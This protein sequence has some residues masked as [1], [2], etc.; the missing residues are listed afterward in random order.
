MPELFDRDEADFQEL[1][2][3]LKI[4]SIMTNFNKKIDDYIYKAQPFAQPVLMHIRNLVHKACP[5][6]EE[7]I[8][9]SFPHFDY[10]GE[11]LCSMASFKQHCAF[12]FWKG[13]IMKDP[14]GILAKPKTAMGHL[15]QIKSLKD[16]PSDKIMLKYIRQAMQLNDEKIKLPARN[17]LTSE[18]EIEVPDILLKALKENKEANVCWQSFSKSH[19]KEYAEWIREAKTIETKNK[20][21]AT[22]IEWLKEG[23][24]RNWKYKR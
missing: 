6:A 7:K 21:L 5:E 11:M 24:D 22:T 3:H 4:K 2:Y 9:W 18:S 17:K 23:K 19:Q 13:S 16:L 8:K 1:I 14:D 12:G 15:G 10:K 20:R